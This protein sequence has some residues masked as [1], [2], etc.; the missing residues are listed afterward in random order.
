MISKYFLWASVIV[1]NLLFLSSC[2]NSS[3]NNVEYSPDAQ[4]YAFS[5]SSKADT[6]RL[7]PATAFTIDQVNGMIF[8][9]EPL[10]FQFNVDSVVLNITGANGYSPFSLVM[11]LLVPDSSYAWVQS[12]SVAL[13]RLLK[14]T[15]TAPDGINS[16]IYHFRLNVYQQDPYL[17][18]WE[19]KTDNYIPS[20]ADE[21]K[22]VVFNNRFITYYKSGTEIDAMTSVV[23]DGVNWS[24]ANLT[25]LPNSVRFSSLVVSGDLA[26]VL[27]E[28][29]K[30]V[31][32]STDGINW[33]Q[34]ATNY[35]VEA[36]YEVLP[37]ASGGDILI[38]VNNNGSLMFAKS[39]DFSEI[40]LLNS[41]PGNIPVK[42]YSAAK[43][44]NDLSFGVKYIILSGGYSADNNS[45][46]DIFIL[47]E[48]D[49]IITHITA[50]KPASVSLKGSRLFFYDNK[51]Y[52]I[53]ASS[54]KN[55]LIYSDN[56]GLDWKKSADNQAFPAEFSYR[57]NASVIV[58]ANNYIWI[59]G[60]IS[61]TQDQIVDVW[62]GK[63]NKFA[64]N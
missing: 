26:F 33:S 10:P 54:E 50:R 6:S 57:T 1:M 14:I 48:K 16:K 43:V 29:T 23:A 45:N 47:Q 12:D 37:S 62:R 13:S 49:G 31:Y 30:K 64:L 59:F 55:M 2:L 21:Q 35:E 46:N 51:P 53:T 8:N 7:L 20:Q 34:I 41:V 38:T 28:A 19:N 24:K 40:K 3:D 11:L 39:K 5:L 52:M 17:I 9:K 60:G 15:T 22:T 58:D 44:K 18:T 4:I 25:G 32:K 27:D 36:I 63:L 42:D 61:S 56:F